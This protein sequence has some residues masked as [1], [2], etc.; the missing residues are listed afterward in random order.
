VGPRAG[1][2]D[3]EKR[4]FL[5]LPGLELRPL[6]RPLRSQSLYRL[7]YPVSIT[8]V[9][10]YYTTYRYRLLFPDISYRFMNINLYPS[11]VITLNAYS[12][13]CRLISL[14][15]GLVSQIV[16]QELPWSRRHFQLVTR[17]SQRTNLFNWCLYSIH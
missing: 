16:H 14:C 10:V 6:G 15:S 3:V 9:S 11:I 12:Y 1:L 4:K 17:L 2:D 5:Y 13:T 8:S 7:H